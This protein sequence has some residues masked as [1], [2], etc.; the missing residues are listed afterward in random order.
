MASAGDVQINFET[1]G[2]SEDPPV[3]LIAGLGAQLIIWP[4][5]FCHGL[6]DRGF[7]VVRYDN[8]DCGLSTILPDGAEYSLADMATDAVAVLDQLQ[9]PAAHVVGHS[10]GG[11]IAQTL[12]VEHRSRVLTLTSMASTTGNPDFGRASDDALVAISQPAAATVD[13][14][15]ERD[16]E[17]R[18]VWASPNWFVEDETRAYFRRAHERSFNPMGGV[19][20][21]HA[22]L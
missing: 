18:R 15:V 14:A 13:E 3:L 16:L 20:Q 12:A 2:E 1:L 7:L 5:E 8:R 19:R 6:V 11:M 17:A 22:L 21:M 10:L 9:I 4:D